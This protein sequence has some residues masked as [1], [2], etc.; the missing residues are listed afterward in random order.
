MS[1]IYILIVVNKA[2]FFDLG[3]VA[4]DTI[5]KVIGKTTDILIATEV[6]NCV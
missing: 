3:G 2:F 4:T 1:Y 5:I 6:P